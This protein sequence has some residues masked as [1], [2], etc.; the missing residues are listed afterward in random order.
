[1]SSALDDMT[2]FYDDDIICCFYRL[3]TM[4]DDDDGASG[5]EIMHGLGDCF[6]CKG[7]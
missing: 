1:M 3:E 7:V 4:G 6:F 5:K 2:L